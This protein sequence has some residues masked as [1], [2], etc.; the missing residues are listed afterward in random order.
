MYRELTVTRTRL[1]GLPVPEHS[2]TDWYHMCDELPDGDLE[3]A[4]ETEWALASSTAATRL[5]GHTLGS[6]ESPDPGIHQM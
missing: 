3:T 2:M 5:M 1:Q 6:M 4:T